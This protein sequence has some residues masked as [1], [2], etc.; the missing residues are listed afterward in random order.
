MLALTTILY[1]FKTLLGK[2]EI[3][4]SIS[5]T[6]IITIGNIKANKTNITTD[7]T[8]SEAPALDL[9]LF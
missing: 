9:I 3:I 6:P 4:S 1:R 8:I 2:I 7:K 5:F